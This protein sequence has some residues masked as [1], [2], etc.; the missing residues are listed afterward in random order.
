[1]VM[2]YSR[3]YLHSIKRDADHKE[4]QKVMNVL[5]Q[6]IHSNEPM[7]M[8][9]RHWICSRMPIIYPE[10][11][12]ENYLDPFDFPECEE[13]L[14]RERYL[15]YFSDVEGWRTTLDFDG[16]IPE[17][18]KERDLQLL[19]K[20][21]NEWR[22][23]V[24]I[25]N[26]SDAIL[27][28]ASKE[29]RDQ[30]KEI[31][32]YCEG[33]FGSNRRKHLEKEFILHSKHMYYLVSEYYEE[34]PPEIEVEVCGHK[35]Y[36]NAFMYIHVLSRHYARI[37]KEHLHNKS[38]HDER[39]NHNDLPKQIQDILEN[40][41]SIS[42]KSFDKQKI[43]FNINS[44]PFVIWLKL[45]KG[46]QPHRYRVNSFYPLDEPTEIAHLQN[47]PNLTSSGGYEFYH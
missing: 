25:T 10:G 17:D 43:Y 30:L 37:T 41:S 3:E 14:F 20:E 46:S 27:Q 5:L 26:H 21:A 35:V 40:Y 12:N 44:D 6:K 11:D 13:A 9:E 4:V 31:K 45:D 47:Y 36:I 33:L 34:N 15:R 39:V 29:T 22:R 28:F 24:E 19:D 7:S 16:I 23:T 32:K 1:M 42:P 8:A 2:T 38:Y 18:K